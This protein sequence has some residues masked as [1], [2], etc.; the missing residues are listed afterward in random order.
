MKRTAKTVEENFAR[1]FRLA[2]KIIVNSGG[3]TLQYPLHLSRSE[4]QEAH[5]M[6]DGFA[7]TA[8]GLADQRAGEQSV[9]MRDVLIVGRL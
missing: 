4:I 6:I 8:A 5:I 2:E 3:Q 1:L 7:R 9:T